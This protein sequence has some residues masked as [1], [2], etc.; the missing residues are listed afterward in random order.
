[1]AGEGEAAAG[2][3]GAD[4]GGPAQVRVLP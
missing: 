1:V 4:A 2:P 3:D